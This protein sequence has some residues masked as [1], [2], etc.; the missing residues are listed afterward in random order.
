MRKETEYDQ[1]G[2]LKSEDTI[3]LEEASDEDIPYQEWEAWI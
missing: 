2:V 1:G 3:Q